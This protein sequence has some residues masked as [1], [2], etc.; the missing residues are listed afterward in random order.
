MK[1]F[2]LAWAAS[3]LF[4]SVWFACLLNTGQ[5]QPSGSGSQIAPLF[6]CHSTVGWCSM[7]LWKNWQVSPGMLGAK[8]RWGG[9]IN[10]ERGHSDYTAQIQNGGDLPSTNTTQIWG[11]TED[12]CFIVNSGFCDPCLFIVPV[13]LR[14]LSTGDSISILRF[15]CSHV[16]HKGI[17]ET[18]G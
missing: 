3:S 5:S 18:L 10:T 9:R 6:T 16:L 14:E 17:D 1:H 7:R 13:S 8:Y 4:F 12:Y 15:Q 11:F 2:V